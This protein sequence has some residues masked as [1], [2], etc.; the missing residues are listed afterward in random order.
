VTGVL[1]KMRSGLSLSRAA[2]EA[3]VSPRTVTRLGATALKKGS[4]G[5]YEA[6]PKDRL[7][8]VL[9]VPTTDGSREIGVR[10][11]KQATLLGEYWAAVHKYLATGETAGLT[12]FHGKQIKDS[13]GKITPLLT[14]TTELNRLGS[15][16]VLS[17]ES[18]Y[19]RSS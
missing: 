15:A 6:K 4:N 18:L 12:R 13:G 2:K 16:G 14:D 10:G 7:F 1:A 11:S 9:K 17:F 19:A 5:R 3:G 8:R